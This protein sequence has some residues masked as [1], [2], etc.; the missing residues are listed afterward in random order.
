L[1]YTRKRDNL[2]TAK[3]TTAIFYQIKRR[4]SIQFFN[5]LCDF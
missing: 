2:V 4:L 3:L 5:I 1:N